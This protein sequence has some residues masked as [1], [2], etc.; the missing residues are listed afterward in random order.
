MTMNCIASI[1]L[2]ASLRSFNPKQKFMIFNK[3][4]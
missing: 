4:L 1:I 3:C 2:E